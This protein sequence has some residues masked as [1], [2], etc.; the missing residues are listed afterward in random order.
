MQ[1]KNIPINTKIILVASGK[2]GVGK[3]TVSFL[4][5]KSLQRKGKKVGILDA[6]IYGPSIPTILGAQNSVPEAVDGIFQ[7]VEKDG[8]KLNSIGFLVKEESALA[9]RGPMLTKALDQLLFSTNW[10]EC[11]YLIVDMPPGTGDIHI[12]FVQK[13]KIFG[14]IIVTTPDI[15]AEKDVIRAIDL[16]KKVNLPILGIIENMSYLKNG[17][18]LISIFSGSS[19]EK[20][21]ENY[22]I[23]LIAKLPIIPMLSGNFELY[24]NKE[25]E[26]NIEN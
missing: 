4:L 5:A 23:K 11:E 3:S 26:I 7:P 10:S 17:D 1:A 21:S 15:V 16:Y 22:G 25:L 14:A 6:D 9:W 20:I 12:S 24:D 2:G 13:A 19:A 8:I 18:D